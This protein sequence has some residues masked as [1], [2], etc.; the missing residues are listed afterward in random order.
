MTNNTRARFVKGD[1]ITVNIFADTETF[2]LINK[3]PFRS[4]EL[5]HNHPDLSDFSANDINIFMGYDSL[6]SMST[7]TNQGKTRVINKTERFDQ[8]KARTNME[9]NLEKRESIDKAV[10]YFLKECYTFGIKRK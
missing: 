10:E 2:H 3:N 8:K 6:K 1:S 7:V 4:L 5:T 9:S